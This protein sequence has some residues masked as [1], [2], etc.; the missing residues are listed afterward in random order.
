MLASTPATEL[1]GA[2][3][4]GINSSQGFLDSALD[5]LG[6]N[7]GGFLEDIAKVKRIADRMTIAG[8]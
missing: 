3:G 6:G 7:G 8:G 5:K 2:M 4:K 1:L